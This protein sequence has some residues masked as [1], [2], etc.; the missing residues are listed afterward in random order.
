MTVQQNNGSD[1]ETNP[2]QAQILQ[3]AMQVFLEQGYAAT[4]MDR[5]AAA[6]GV[7]KQTIYSYFQDKQGLFKA[8]IERVTIDR[9]QH[10]FQTE[11]L[12]GEPDRLL[13][14]FATSF[15]QNMKDPE[16]LN[17]LRI[18][19]SESARF[20]ELAALYTQTVIKKGR[21]LLAAYFQQHPELRITD[22]EA[23]AHIFC[24]SLVSFL[25]AQEL[26]HGKEVAP[27]ED[28][29]LINALIPLFTDRST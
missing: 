13:R 5:V 4:T 6:A 18:I 1:R 16:F 23:T 9:M 2:K 21:S 22:P 19:I 25:I 3:G 28:D 27:L 7:S 26:L 15:L 12:N 20:P 11:N 17:L 10:I 8:L 14:H 29:R 24:G